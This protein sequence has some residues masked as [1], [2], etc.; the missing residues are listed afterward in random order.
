MSQLL[1][2]VALISFAGQ[3][4]TTAGLTEEE[5]ASA[6]AAVETAVDGF[7]GAWAAA[8]VDRGMSYMAAE[9]TAVT[10]RGQILRGYATI[11]AAWRP[12]FRN[13][14]SQQIAFE[15][16]HVTVFEGFVCVQQRG[17]FEVTDKAGAT[18]SEIP[19]AFTTVWTKAQ[20]EWKI[21]AAHRTS[22]TPTQAE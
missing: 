9:A 18:G 13:V 5:R 2:A 19:F 8:D 21:V 11:D 16:S 10:S 4:P 6:A 7:W 22:V 17:T 12:L 1:L 3:P 14:A 20:G 15:E